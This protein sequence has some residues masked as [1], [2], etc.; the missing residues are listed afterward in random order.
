[1]TLKTKQKTKQAKQE[2]VFK[3]S[4]M[5]A[6]KVPETYKGGYRSIL[7]QRVREFSKL[8]GDAVQKYKNYREHQT[9]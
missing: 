7:N 6:A 3:S 4:N 5:D 9:E 8:M 2:E 1:M